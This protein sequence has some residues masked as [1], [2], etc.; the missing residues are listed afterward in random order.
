MWDGEMAWLPEHARV[1]RYDLRG[2]GTSDDPT[3]PYSNHSDLLALLD[4]LGE[5]G[6]SLVGL[7]AGAQVAL[8][9]ALEA[10]DRVRSMILVSPS[11][12]GY[13]PEQMPPF[14]ADLSAAL[15]AGDYE[16]AN[17]VL[18]ASPIM[19]VPPEFADTVRTMVE[20]N[21]RLWTLPY[22]LVE[23][24]SPPAIERLD[25]I[26]AP[27]L[28]LTGEDD[29]AAIRAQGLLLEQRLPDVRLVTIP[30]G[31]HLLN[32]TSPDAFREAVS[33]FLSLPQE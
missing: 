30:G 21:T 9:V 19:A 25:A 2:Q 1:L 27:T 20:D 23:Q 12:A 26:Q 32:M 24:L 29:L 17:E 5:G 4:E 10:P 22:S 3:D 14:F 7:S 13:M 15:Q 8:D 31:G 28:V 11:L 33:A 18:L 6:A 16:A